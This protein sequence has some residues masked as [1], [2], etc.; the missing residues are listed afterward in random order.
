MERNKLIRLFALLPLAT[1]LTMCTDDMA[2]RG[3]GYDEAHTPI[4]LNVAFDQSEKADTRAADGLQNTGFLPTYQFLRLFADQNDD[5]YTQYET[6]YKPTA[7]TTIAVQ[8]GAAVPY[9][10]A[11][12]TTVNVYGWYP[13][14]D[15]SKSFTVQDDQSTQDNYV[16]SDL[17][18]ADKVQS[19]RDLST[20]VVTPATL[21]FRHAMSKIVLNVTAGDGVTVNNVRLAG[22][23]KTVAINDATKTALTL[24]SASGEAGEVTVHSTSFTSSS[25]KQTMAAVIPPQSVSGDFIKVN[26]TVGGSSRDVTFALGEAKT[27]ATNQ[28]YTLTLT[29]NKQN[30]GATLTINNWAASSSA[31]NIIPSTEGGGGL[32]SLDANIFDTTFSTTSPTL[33]VT[34]TTDCSSVQATSTNTGVATVSYSGKVTTITAVHAG[35]AKVV[36]SEVG[37]DDFGVVEVNVAKATTSVTTAPTKRADW[38]YDTN[39]YA[40]LTSAGASNY[41][42]MKYSTDNSTWSTSIPTGQN[43]GSYTVYYKAE[44]PDYTDYQDDES[45]WGT[46]TVAVNKA[47]QTPSLSTTSLTVG[48]IG[49]TGT[50]TVTRSGNGNI[51]AVSSNTSK[52]T[53]SVNQETGVVTVTNVAIGS[54]TITVTVAE[55]DNYLAYT[56]S[57]KQVAVTTI[58]DPGIPAADVTSTNISLGWYLAKNGKV[59]ENKSDADDIGTGAVAAIAYIGTLDKYFDKFLAIALEDAAASYAYWSTQLTAVNTWAGTHA[60]TI[61]S[62]TYNTGTTGS[63]YYDKVSSSFTTVTA[64]NGTQPSSLKQGWRMPSM[65]DIN[66]A[67]TG[68]GGGNYATLRDW[69]SSN[70]GTNMQSNYYWSSSEYSSSSDG[71]WARYFDNGYWYSNNKTG[72]NGYVRAVFAY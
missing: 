66:A 6:T 29:V 12:E 26:V 36:I 42:T 34:A 60:V 52:A 14:L 21:P 3:L 23:K 38:T 50:F 20:G 8:S 10:K 57:D 63:S 69:F 40:L 48:G 4:A 54:A 1:V 71:A 55:G 28:T 35:T 64:A 53:T 61:G 41:G 45:T 44:S 17:L 62:T 15:S 39:S 51:T 7:A 19:T 49:N 24:G 5:N 72:L 46:F 70:G 65:T 16:K 43:A 25:G 30:I 11:G 37:G 18:L 9:F 56:A 58:A 2:E 68:L 59:Y 33:N 32:L 47:A 67:V 22:V 31:A 27:L 13:A